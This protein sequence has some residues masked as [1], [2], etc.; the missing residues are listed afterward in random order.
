MIKKLTPASITSQKKWA[1]LSTKLKKELGKTLPDTDKDGVPNGF[2]CRPKNRRRQESFLPV[3]ATYLNSNPVIEVGKP[4][5]KGTSGAVF[6]VKGN[7]NLVV[8][9]PL[10]YTNDERTPSVRRNILSYTVNRIKEEGNRYYDNQ[11]DA[12]P[13]MPPTKIVT[14]ANNGLYS[15]EII[16]LVR[17]R[18]VPMT[19]TETTVQPHHL[20]RLTEE[21]LELIR[22]KLIDL[23]YTKYAI[24]DGLQLGLDKANRPMLYDT[25]YMER[26]AHTETAFYYN[27]LAWLHF[28]TNIGKYTR[29]YRK[30]EERQ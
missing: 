2:D 7:R 30:V 8:K 24:R 18:V 16:G 27:N 4:I 23:S 28:L 13:L 25:G 6:S 3:D 15:G 12:V 14:M 10:G 5:A 21:Q 19:D 1:G 11:M 29:R 17:P 20:K 22:Q 26:T 9:V